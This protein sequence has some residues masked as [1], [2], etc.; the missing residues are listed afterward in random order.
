MA[1]AN[2]V[3]PGDSDAVNL[4]KAA[5]V[6]SFVT[7]SPGGCFTCH[8]PAER[9]TEGVDVF[10]HTDGCIVAWLEDYADQQVAAEHGGH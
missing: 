6:L 7:L 2:F 4:H 3:N 5:Q 9:V 8:A 1:T 10:T